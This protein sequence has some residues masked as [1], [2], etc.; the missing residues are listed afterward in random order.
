MM[1]VIPILIGGLIIIGVVFTLRN[2]INPAPSQIPTPAITSGTQTTAQT[3]SV[4][5]G[6]VQATRPM[7]GQESFGLAVCE[8]VSQ[9]LVEKIVGKPIVE[10]KDHSDNDTTG[11]EYVINKDMLENVVVVVA[12]IDAENQKKFYESTGKS[13]KIDPAIGMAIFMYGMKQKVRSEEYSF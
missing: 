8:E 5:K 7:I 9:A 2:T 13:I 1:R 4:T 6:S 10:V 3:D 12:Y 11:C